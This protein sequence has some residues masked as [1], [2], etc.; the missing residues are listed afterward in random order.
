ALGST[1]AGPIIAKGAAIRLINIPGPVVFP[2]EPL[3]FGTGPADLEATLVNSVSDATWTGPVTFTPGGNHLV[4]EPTRTLHFTG[5][6]G[7]AGGFRQISSGVL[8]FTGSAPN[9]Y[10][11]V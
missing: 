7:G 10:A 9:T 3:T 6:L 1:Q 11:G 4:A 2:P 5:A 8:E